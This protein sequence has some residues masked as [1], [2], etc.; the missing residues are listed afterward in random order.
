MLGWVDH[1]MRHCLALGQ[2]LEEVSEQ[3]VEVNKFHVVGD[4]G[5]VDASFTIHQ[6]DVCC[7]KV[8]SVQSR[9]GRGRKMCLVLHTYEIDDVLVSVMYNG[10]EDRACSSSFMRLGLPNA[11]RRT[12]PGQRFEV[13]V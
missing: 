6:S 11:R 5:G 7:T 8:V 2:S 13:T 3:D 9:R 12:R 10:V 1:A 4:D